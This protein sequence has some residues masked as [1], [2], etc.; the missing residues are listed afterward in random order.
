MKAV[1]PLNTATDRELQLIAEVSHDR[2][3]DIV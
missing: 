1:I 2:S 3:S